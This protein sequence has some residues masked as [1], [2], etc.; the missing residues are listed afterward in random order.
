MN[1]AASRGEPTYSLQIGLLVLNFGAVSRS[2]LWKVKEYQDLSWQ[3]RHDDKIWNQNRFFEYMCSSGVHIIIVLEADD[4]YASETGRKDLVDAGYRL[5]FSTDGSQMVA[6]R[7]GLPTDA[8]SFF[9]QKLVDS[10]LLTRVESLPQKLRVPRDVQYVIWEIDMGIDEHRTESGAPEDY[11]YIS[12]SGLQKLRVLSYHVHHKSATHH[13]AAT[14][15][16]I[17]FMWRAAVEYEVDIVGGDANQSSTWFRKDKQTRWQPQLGA[18]MAVG[19][20][21]QEALNEKLFLHAQ[22]QMLSLAIDFLNNNFQVVLGR[23]AQKLKEDSLESGFV[24][25][26]STEDMDCMVVAILS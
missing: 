22:T 25:S 16:A 24:V 4:L 7:C 17:Q 11:R 12:R 9:V 10:T 19:R 13:A 6:C 3:R 1:S 18:I 15:S 14:V 2:N 20:A 21:Y 26:D 23:A 5:G 8:D